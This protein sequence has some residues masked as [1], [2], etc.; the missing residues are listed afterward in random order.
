MSET[1]KSNTKKKVYKKA[2]VPGIADITENTFAPLMSKYMFFVYQRGTKL[3]VT[4]LT[5]IYA[6]LA[7]GGRLTRYYPRR[8]GQLFFSSPIWFSVICNL[9]LTFRLSPSFFS[10]GGRAPTIFFFALLLQDAVYTLRDPYSSVSNLEWK[11]EH[12]C[13]HSGMFFDSLP[14]HL[15]FLPLYL[16]PTRSSCS[17]YSPPS[18]APTSLER[19]Q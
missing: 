18:L 3:K 15:P 7:E 9:S 16:S 2:L 8:H 1:R 6:C 13:L 5:Y 4:Y 17:L 10:Q 19:T 11:P 12:D 14:N